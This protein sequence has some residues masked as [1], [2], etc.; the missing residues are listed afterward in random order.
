MG[1][2]KDEYGFVGIEPEINGTPQKVAYTGTAASSAAMGAATSSVVLV[3][4]TDCHIAYGAAPTATAN[5]LFL[6]AKTPFRAS[7]M[8][9]MKFSVIQDAAGGNLHIQECL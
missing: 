7:V 8:P 3:A 1:R 9:G 4:T 6:P 2:R 5:S